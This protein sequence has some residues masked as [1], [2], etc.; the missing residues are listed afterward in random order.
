MTLP[1]SLLPG[2]YRH[3]GRPVSRLTPSLDSENAVRRFE[4]RDLVSMPPR[5]A[6]A[7]LVLLTA[8]LAEIMADR[9][10]DRVLFSDPTTGEPVHEIAWLI[11]RGRRLK[12]VI[13]RRSPARQLR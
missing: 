6:W 8:H 13:D 3:R 2:R 11:E 10:R 9:G 1:I 4:H 7:E 12:R 5:E